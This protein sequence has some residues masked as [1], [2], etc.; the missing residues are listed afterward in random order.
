VLL[1]VREWR[2]DILEEHFEELE[3]LWNRRL[4]AERSPLVD[5]LGLRRLDARIDAHADALVLAG[6]HATLLLERGLSG[7]EPPAA[8]AAA[9][10][11]SADPA[12]D[13]RLARAFAENAPARAAI[14]T[15]LTLRASPGLR[16]ALAALP[17]AD[18]ELAAATAAVLA[19][20][21]E[22]S[23]QP[24]LEAPSPAARALAWRAVRRLGAT[25][26]A[27]LHRRAL[28]DPD[29]SVRREAIGAAGQSGWKA[30]LA[31]LR[32]RAAQP[33]PTRLEDHLLFAA[34]SEPAD[35]PLVLALGEAEALG[36]DRYQVLAACGRAA[37]VE[38]LVRA[39]KQRDPVE[40]ALAAVAFARITGLD[41]SRPERTPLLP[42]GAP[43]DELADEIRL[44]DAAAA[45]KAWAAVR[46]RLGAS[47]WAYG[48]DV[49]AIALGAWPDTFDLETRWRLQL[50][51]AQTRLDHE[52]FPFV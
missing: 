49:D 8:A 31:E 7:E 51:A 9:L 18:P 21:G 34:F 37:A 36:W 26:D 50:H 12:A 44:P 38:A 11:L 47:R 29:P 24:L 2:P 43:P 23:P 32:A 27:A 46:G 1:A 41:V 6:D 28:A 14:A 48:V 20:H 17:A 5:A 25:V 3:A 19:A 10:V 45:E 42:A 16:R 52:R 33:D 15:A 39:I 35:L 40:G 30:V 22:G 13:Q 4:R